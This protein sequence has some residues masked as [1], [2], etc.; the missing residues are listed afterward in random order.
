[1]FEGSHHSAL[2][3]QI[4]HALITLVVLTLTLHLATARAS[5]SLECNP[6]SAKMSCLMGCFG[7]FEAFGVELYDM[8]ACCRDCRLT[9]A[10][11]IDDG[12]SRC[13]RDYIRR[14]WLKRIG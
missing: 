13:S 8:A 3:R 1:M 6:R 5:T 14:S 12:P 4:R 9:N 11:I 7:C 10:E 2:A